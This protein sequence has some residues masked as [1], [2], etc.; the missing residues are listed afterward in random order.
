VNFSP[1]VPGKEGDEEGKMG[2]LPQPSLLLE[3]I[4]G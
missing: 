1:E 2:D 4:R 3:R